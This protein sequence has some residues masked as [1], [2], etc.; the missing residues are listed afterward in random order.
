MRAEKLREID[1][2]DLNNQ[3]RES[4]E[5]LFRFRFQLSMGQSEGLTKYRELKRDRA[6]IMGI[7]RE[8]EIKGAG[9]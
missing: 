3:L 6:R 8:R 2:A 1:T 9:K 4:E 7:L 5:Q